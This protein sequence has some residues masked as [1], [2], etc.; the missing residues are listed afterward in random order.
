MA[1]IIKR[2]GLVLA[3]PSSKYDIR[4]DIF[5]SDGSRAEMCGNASRCFA[6]FVYEKG[7]VK[8][9]RIEIETLAGLIVAELKIEDGLVESV[10]VYMTGGAREVLKGQYCYF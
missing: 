5:N 6:K 7:L 10:R 1:R 2:E 8:K 4:M 3:G 9:K